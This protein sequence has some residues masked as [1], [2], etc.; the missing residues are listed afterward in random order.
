MKSI[1]SDFVIDIWYKRKD[2][3][4]KNIVF[5]DVEFIL[6]NNKKLLPKLVSWYETNPPRSEPHIGIAW[7]HKKDSINH[8]RDILEKADLIVAYNPWGLDY[9][10]LTYWNIDIVKCLLKTFDIYNQVFKVISLKGTGSLS[11]VSKLNGGL[12]K[13]IR[14]NTSNFEFQKQCQRD[15]KILRG[16]FE[17]LLGGKFKS[18]KY[19]LIDIE[20]LYWEKIQNNTLRKR[21]TSNWTLLKILAN[22]NNN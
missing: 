7:H 22:Q 17:K 10:A 3:I 8:C 5:F 21:K 9:K 12:E 20:E 18:S 16:L 13:I 4:R 19:G 2:L 15:V 11:E 6:S 14:K 1:Y